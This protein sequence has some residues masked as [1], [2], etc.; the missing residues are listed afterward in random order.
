MI[1]AGLGQVVVKLDPPESNSVGFQF[2][3]AFSPFQEKSIFATVISVGRPAYFG[4]KVKAAR[5][6]KVR[7]SALEKE[8]A[9]SCGLRDLVP[10]EVAPGDRVVIHYRYNLEKLESHEEETSDGYKIVAYSDLIARLDRDSVYPLNG[11]VF[12]VPYDTT[13]DYMVRKSDGDRRTWY[14]IAEGCDV[15][16][17][18]IQ[19][20]YDAKFPVLVGKVVVC[21]PMAPIQVECGLFQKLS[22]G[23]PI[24]VINRRHI[25]AFVTEHRPSGQSSKIIYA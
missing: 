17:Y 8:I 24:S 3:D 13:P 9:E 10:I 7:L 21:E 11:N 5:V 6:G 4:D 14:V 25:C 12:V 15:L 1:F 2:S 19:E 18:D 23:H 22:S 16:D 20:S